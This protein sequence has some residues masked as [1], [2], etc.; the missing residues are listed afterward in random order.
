MAGGLLIGPAAVPAA[1]DSS[2]PVAGHGWGHGRGMGQYG[3][4]GYAL[5][6]QP[7][8]WILDHFYG[9]TSSS[10]IGNNLMSV[11]LISQD[12]VNLMVTS[13]APFTVGGYPIDASRGIRL[14][15]NSNGTYSAF[16]STACG[17]SVVYSWTFNPD[18]NGAVTV[19][20]AVANPGDN[21]G[22]MLTIC[23]GQT[24]RGYLRFLY[25]DGLVRTVNMVLTEDYL[26]GVVPNESPSSWP[27]AALQAQAVA[28][29]SYA[30]A[31]NRNW[32]AKTC[33]TTSCQVYRGAN[34]EPANSNNAI[35]AT[36][37]VVRVLN[38]GGVAS[39]EFSSSTGGWTAGGTFPAVIDDGD[40]TPSNPNHNWSTS[41]PVSSLQAVYGIGSFQ[42]IT[43]TS[44]NGFGDFGGR[45][46]NVSIQGSAKT[47]N[48]TGG[49]FRDDWG[50]KSDW[51]DFGNP[52]FT[53][54]LRNTNSAGS[55]DASFIYGGPPATPVACDWNGNGSRTIGIYDGG[56]WLLRNSN[57]PGQPDLTI[58]YGAAG[59]TPVCG[60]WDGNGTQT[61]GVYVN[62]RWLLR[63]SNTP[64][65][66]D[67]VFDY[68]A[69]GYTPV[70]GNW[71]GAGGDGIGVY[72]NGLWLLRN[73]ASAGPADAAFSYG[74]SGYAPVAGNWDNAGGDSVGVFVGGR[75]LLRNSNTAGSPNTVF[76]Y[77]IPG[78]VPIVADWD[79]N[80]AD[81]V[82]VV[83]PPTG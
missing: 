19:R 80:G 18:D 45:A 44:R 1:A 34:S 51:F 30:T 49:Q 50:L 61:I 74:A 52:F 32:Y 78:Y 82:G 3:A 11:R 53:W 73:A 33:D 22:N 16:V 63:N 14:T 27:P 42:G 69:A 79:G 48:R 67:I 60:D 12:G 59:Y 39:T 29:R 46:L 2:I 23:G 7:A 64:G 10:S 56:W 65:P 68:G 6:N 72:R 4:L 83:A 55:P 57:T 66:P 54:Y 71:D 5:A 17:G 9:G 36:A 37:G 81:S 25:G 77:G 28:A 38:G 76:D 43:V 13:Q 26:R 40:A 41:I 35:A 15:A 8:S 20:S 62:G 70:V 75:W 24:Y 47:V 58:N 31:Q 21:L